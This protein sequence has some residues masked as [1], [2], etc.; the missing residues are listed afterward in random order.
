[1]ERPGRT[2]RHRRLTVRVQVD[3]DTPWGPR[4]DVATTLGAGGLFIAAQEP[5]DEGE[6]LSVRFTLYEGGES[7]EIRARVVWTN[8]P[9]ESR[10]GARG[11]GIEFT[12]PRASAR[13]ADELE[14]FEPAGAAP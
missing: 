6:T 11:M 2:R 1:M 4:R 12:D 3:Y 10:P 5:L 7:H 9:S 13:L 8:H 14:E